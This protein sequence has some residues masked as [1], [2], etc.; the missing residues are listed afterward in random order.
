MALFSWFRRR[1]PPPPQLTGDPAH[2]MTQV[3]LRIE[4]HLS[5]L[6]DRSRQLEKL[7]RRLQG[8]ETALRQI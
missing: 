6:S 3:L 4:A 8:I 7:D 2:D 5:D 1:T